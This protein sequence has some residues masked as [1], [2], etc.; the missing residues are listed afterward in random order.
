MFTLLILLMVL[1]ACSSQKKLTEEAPF[2]VSKAICQTWVGGMEQTGHGTEVTLTLDTL[3]MDQITLKEMYFRGRV[4]EI[5]IG[6]TVDG[7]QAKCN[8]I[9]QPKEISMHSDSTKEV[10]NQPPRVRSKKELKFPFELEP[11]EV[12]ISYMENEDLKFFKV[13]DVVDKPGRVY[14]SRPNN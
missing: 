13:S 1:F 10:G 7:I 5:T 8:F 9:E 2:T 6:D 11:N 14:Q 3:P 12:V 4:G